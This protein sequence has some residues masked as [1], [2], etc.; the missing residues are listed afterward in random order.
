MSAPRVSNGFAVTFG[1]LALIILSTPAMAE[2]NLDTANRILQLAQGWQPQQQQRFGQT[3]QQ[4]PNRF[5]NQLRPQ[6]R[7]QVPGSGSEPVMCQTPGYTCPDSR[8]QCRPLRRTGTN[9]YQDYYECIPQG[10]TP[11]GCLVGYQR[12]D[13]GDGSYMCRPVYPRGTCAGGNATW[14]PRDNGPGFRC[15]RIT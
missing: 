7:P 5:M 9:Q 11:Q 15:R 12:Q 14:G 4:V 2:S 3:P 6:L 13:N 10:T 8:Y 1:L